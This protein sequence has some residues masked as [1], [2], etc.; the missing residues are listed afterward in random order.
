MRD[1]MEFSSS[2][3]W[4]GGGNGAVPPRYLPNANVFTATC[5]ALT[6]RIFETFS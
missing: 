4:D 1:H 3:Y 5:Y 2:I 6:R